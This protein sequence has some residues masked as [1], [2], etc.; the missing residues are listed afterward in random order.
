MQNAQIC[1]APIFRR[2][3]QQST[4]LRVER[5]VVVVSVVIVVF[6]IVCCLFQIFTKIS[7][8][9]ETG[10]GFPTNQTTSRDGVERWSSGY[11]RR[12]VFERSW[13][14]IPALDGHNIFY[15][16]FLLK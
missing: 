5:V 2:I 4:K 3:L 8:K 10:G 9:P 13:V 16:D 12:L 7:S 14:Q 1:N 15:F 6:V 11:G